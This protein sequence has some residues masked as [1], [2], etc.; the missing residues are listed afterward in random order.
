M[1]VLATEGVA[2]YVLKRADARLELSCEVEGMLVGDLIE[3]LSEAMK[4]ERGA[5]L[6]M[7]VTTDRWS[8]DRP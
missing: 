8:H 2:L 5:G 7:K 4:S 1:T 3:L 6:V